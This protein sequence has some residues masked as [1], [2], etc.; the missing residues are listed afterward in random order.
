[1][2][3]KV[4]MISRVRQAA[5]RL[6]Q[7]GVP[8]PLNDAEILAAHVL[9]VSRGRLLTIDDAPVGFDTAYAAAIGRRAKREPLQHITGVAHFRH[10]ALAVGPGVFVPRP[11]T[12]STA[13]AAID[14]AERLIESGETPR[15]VDLYS[16]SGAIALSV[17]HEVP[18][19]EVHA[20]EA[21]DAAIIWLRRNAKGRAVAVHHQDAGAYTAQTG[22]VDIVVANPPYVPTEAIVRDPEVTEHDPAAA[23]W[24]GVDGL[25]AMRTLEKTA[26]ELLK[27]GGLVVAEHADVQGVVAPDIFRSAGRW[28]DVADHDDLNGRPRY[29][30]ARLGERYEGEHTALRLR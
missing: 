20:V 7:A 24:S 13:G 15:V 23:L 19:A 3:P 1:M 21:D 27:P 16:G 29:L 12:E 4:P 30:T 10:I 22:G 25:D 28:T 11:E 9:D 18:G 17:A 5:H 14:E 2:T 6:A 26:S 8:S